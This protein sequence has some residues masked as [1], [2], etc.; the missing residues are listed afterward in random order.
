[1]DL[2]QKARDYIVDVK[3]FDDHFQQATKI[4]VKTGLKARIM[5]RTMPLSFHRICHVLLDRFLLTEIVLNM[6]QNLLTQTSPCRPHIRG[7][8]YQLMRHLFL[9][10]YG[11]FLFKQICQNWFVNNG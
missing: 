5:Y 4:K 1:M 2:Y 6:S 7:A 9:S 10:I 8:I 3:V 11:I